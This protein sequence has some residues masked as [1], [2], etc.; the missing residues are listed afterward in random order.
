MPP[1]SAQHDGAKQGYQ[2]INSKAQGLAWR[3]PSPQSSPAKFGVKMES[4][5]GPAQEHSEDDV[6][7]VTLEPVHRGI[8]ES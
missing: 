2:R 1:P 4:G 3:R 7:S 6:L 8:C 5:E